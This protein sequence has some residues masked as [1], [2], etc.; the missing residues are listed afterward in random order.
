MFFNV[1]LPFKALTK[2]TKK[3]LELVRF[4]V[5]TT[6]P[7]IQP[8]HFYLPSSAS[9]S[10]FQSTRACFCY[11][12][13]RHFSEHN[14]KYFNILSLF[15]IINLIFLFLFAHF[16]SFSFDP[17]YLY[18]LLLYFVSNMNL[19]MFAHTFNQPLFAFHAPILLLF[20]FTS[21]WSSYRCCRPFWLPIQSSSSATVVC[22]AIDRLSPLCSCP[23]HSLF[24]LWF[25]YHPV[26]IPPVPLPTTFRLRLITV[27]KHNST[28]VFGLYSFFNLQRRTL[29]TCPLSDQMRSI[30]EEGVKRPESR[31]INGDLPGDHSCRSVH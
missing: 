10:S 28:S 5:T 24:V 14:Y 25:L 4:A 27:K 20:Q 31:P 6:E 30:A 8:M 7:A 15:Y 3:V 12:L 21:F 22:S 18:F 16:S 1:K 23:Y 13:N 19:N 11:R 2:E 17:T 9:S 29:T 26:P